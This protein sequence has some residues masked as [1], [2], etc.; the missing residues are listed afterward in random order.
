MC[1]RGSKH[2]AGEGRGKAC[3]APQQ[4]AAAALARRVL[5]TG[6]DRA[7]RGRWGAPPRAALGRLHRGRGGGARP[8]REAPVPRYTANSPQSPPRPEPASPRPSPA[9]SAGRGRG[10]WGG[11]P[12]GRGVLVPGHW[13]P[14]GPGR[15]RVCPHQPSEPGMLPPLRPTGRAGPGCCPRS[16]RCRAPVQARP[17]ALRTAVAVPSP[18]R[19]IC[20]LA[21]EGSSHPVRPL[22]GSRLWLIASE[23]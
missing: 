12:A 16:G 8:A 15:R 14:A 1:V 18:P 23:G 9:G 21:A 5:R 7:S 4:H 22:L 10:D 13:L 20:S 17:G 3:Q 19:G 6:A 2:R 11:R